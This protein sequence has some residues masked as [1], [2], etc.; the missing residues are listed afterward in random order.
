MT[1]TIDA[2]AKAGAN[3][4]IEVTPPGAA[5]IDDFSA[6]LAE[7]TTVNVTFLPGTDPV[8]TID[9]AKRLRDA[10]LVPVPHIAARS[11]TSKEQLADLVADMTSRANVDEVLV[12]GGGVTNPVGEFA[13]T[14]E[15]LETG[16][17]QKAGIRKIGVS[18]HP[19]DSPDI[20]DNQL[21]EALAWKNDYAKKEGL[22]LYIETQFCFDADAVVA[23]EKRIRA[24]GNML[25]IRIGIPGPATIKTLFRFA[26]ISGIG[27][28][29]RFIAKQARN[30]TKLLTV[31][32]PHLLIAGL[33]EAMANDPE[34]KLNH[35]HYYPFGGVAKTAVW[36]SQVASSQVKLL[37]KGGFQ[38]LE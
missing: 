19:E 20:N 8:D 16:I 25:P 38:V 21:A 22:E 10:G 27:P 24:D 12:I 15:V 36:A 37:P 23:W 35:F 28:S 33:A 32:S 14:M 31:Q 6:I 1:A 30:V 26:Q 5:K 4:S 2:I 9:V 13:S 17:L 7:G 34:T 18:G 11:L 29:M 3:W